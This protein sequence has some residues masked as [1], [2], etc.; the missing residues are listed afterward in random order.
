MQRMQNRPFEPTDLVA[1]VAAQ[2]AARSWPL[3]TVVV[4]SIEGVCRLFQRLKPLL[5][6]GKLLSGDIRRVHVLASQTDARVTR[7][8]AVLVDDGAADL[9]I[10]RPGTA[11]EI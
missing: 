10:V 7:Q 5:R 9:G 2:P 6:L 3:A 4:P 8:L 1:R 11:V